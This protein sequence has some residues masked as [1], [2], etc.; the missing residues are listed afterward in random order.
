M[1]PAEKELR[2]RQ[3]IIRLRQAGS[4]QQLY[5]ADYTHT[6][7]YINVAYACCYL[8]QLR[9]LFI[10]MIL[11]ASRLGSP[12]AIKGCFIALMFSVPATFCRTLRVAM[13]DCMLL[14]PTATRKCCLH[15]AV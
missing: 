12:V 11:R 1:Q 5:A 8:A 15:K 7:L 14:Y 13:R 4:P 10:R 2:R 9:I 3:F 6:Y